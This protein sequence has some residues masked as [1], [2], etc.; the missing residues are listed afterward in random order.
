MAG[1]V[2]FM[3]GRVSFMAGRVSFMTGRVSFMAGRVSLMAGRVSR[4]SLVL[5]RATPFDST[6]KPPSFRSRCLLCGLGTLFCCRDLS[7]H[8]RVLL[9]L[10]NL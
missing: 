2:S 4:V 3:A 6:P 9:L 10:S 8:C 7:Y 5:P 1:R